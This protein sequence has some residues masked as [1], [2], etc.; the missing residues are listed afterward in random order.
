V[1]KPLNDRLLR[2]ALTA[3]SATDLS[4]DCI[5]ASIAAAWSDGSLDR[6]ARA[7]VE[8]H[9]AG[10][11]RCQALLAAIARTAPDAPAARW[12]HMSVIR[13]AVPAAAAL[14][15]AVLVWSTLP[16]RR[17]QQAPSPVSEPSPQREAEKTARP[18]E[19]F[20]R[21]EPVGGV[22]RDAPAAGDRAEGAAGTAKADAANALKKQRAPVDQLDAFTALQKDAR[23]NLD[24]GKPAAAKA[25]AEPGRLEERVSAPAAQA[26]AAVEGGRSV[27]EVRSPDQA[28]R[29]RIS[30]GG[31]VDR[32]TDGGSTWQPQQT[33]GA[34][35]SAGSSPSPSV[36]W[37]V[38]PGGT[39]LLTTDGGATWLRVPLSDPIDLAGIVTADARSAT[40]TAVDGRRF[41]TGDGGHTWILVP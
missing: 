33:G 39:V 24:E 9:A 13:W 28:M 23:Q 12:W 14:S 15:A 41:R 19:Q 36:C 16:E 4:A 17:T 6:K 31:G 26:T 3:Q 8:A 40:A 20:L 10:C 29:W 5:D 7:A 34:I 25:P 32:T 27:T 1:S 22:G 2:E 38:G 21:K 18:D 37:L 35:V 30:P 11:D